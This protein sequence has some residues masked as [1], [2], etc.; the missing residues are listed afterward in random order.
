MSKVVKIERTRNRHTW[1]IGLL[2]G[3]FYGYVHPKMKSRPNAD[4]FQIYI[5]ESDITV[6]HLKKDVDDLEELNDE[7]KRKQPVFTEK[8]RITFQDN[9]FAETYGIQIGKYRITTPEI[10]NTQKDGSKCF[11]EIEAII[12][13]QLLD[14]VSYFEEVV[15]SSPEEEP[16]NVEK[17]K[18]NEGV[19]K[20][21][22][23]RRI[24]AQQIGEA[25]TS[26]IQIILIILSAFL[27]GSILVGLITSIGPWILLLFAIPLATQLLPRIF[28]I[29]GRL[30]GYGILSFLV[31][32][33]LISFFFS[34]T[35]L[36]DGSGNE[37]TDT[38][39]EN[40]EPIL[41]VAPECDADSV[42][43]HQ[44]SWD[45]NF[46]FSATMNFSVTCPETKSSFKVRSKYNPNLVAQFGYSG[47]YQA[48]IHPDSILF[49]KQLMIDFQKIRS[50]LDLNS[51][52]FADLIVSSVQNIPYKLLLQGPCQPGF[53]NDNFVAEYLDQG[54][55]C[56]PYV[57]FGVYGPA[58]FIKAFG[59]DCDTKALFLFHHLDQLGYDV[60][61]LVS[62][63]YGHA[64]LGINLPA[65]GVYKKYGRKKYYLWETS[66]AGFLPGYINPGFENMLKWEFALISSE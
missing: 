56:T 65:E 3:K 15:I 51:L 27:G 59:G 18:G 26:L 64:V 48:L 6:H 10:F 31:L 54:G 50:N 11:G 7:R 38:T 24:G 23:K 20:G 19:N 30:L 49:D 9:R 8:A 32:A 29:L 35:S 62:K 44:H 5:Y 61:L 17:S 58:E 39:P 2:K 52:E 41:V 45:T 22:K 36:T 33:F 16:I 63:T 13:F 42:F 47:L 12:E 25:I 46:G 66:N 28:P 1:M 57:D 55:E 40:R 53:Y 21:P 34:L 60:A 14:Q 37:V 4:F 43:N